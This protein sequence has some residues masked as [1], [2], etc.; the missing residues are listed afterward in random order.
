[1]RSIALR[2]LLALLSTL[3]LSIFPLPAVLNGLRP[4]L[5]L[6]LILYIQC[7]LPAYYHLISVIIVG[8]C[9]D[10]LLSTVIGEHVFALL[11]VGW[12]INS[13]SRRFQF[14]TMGQQMIIV[15]FLCMVYQSAL[16][17]VDAFSGFNYSLIT[18]ISSAIIGMMFWPWLRVLADDTLGDVVNRH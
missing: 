16:L 15:G 17:L 8:L 5:T 6:L 13:K 4:P 11:L 3:I 9:M 2:L 18:T 10:A 14:F 7:Y 12:L 1:M